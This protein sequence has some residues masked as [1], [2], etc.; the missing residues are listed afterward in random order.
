MK[1]HE[2][3]IPQPVTLEDFADHFKRNIGDFDS[4][5]NR[6]LFTGYVESKFKMREIKEFLNLSDHTMVFYYR[7]K[8]YDHLETDEIYRLKFERL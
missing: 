5:E 6:K 8:H 3:F 4:V 2:R 7:Q 1:M